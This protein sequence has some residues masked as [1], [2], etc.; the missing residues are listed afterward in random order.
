MSVGS[1]SSVRPPKCLL[2]S[3]R[4]RKARTVASV[5][6]SVADLLR[7]HDVEVKF[8]RDFRTAYGF[9]VEL[10]PFGRQIIRANDGRVLAVLPPPDSLLQHRDVGNTM[11]FGEVIGSR[12]SVTATA[13]DD[14]VI[15]TLEVGR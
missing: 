6:A 4:W 11:I 3:A 13:N 2:T 14:N 7:V 9:T 5:C 1:M 12:H 10:Y 8:V 15:L